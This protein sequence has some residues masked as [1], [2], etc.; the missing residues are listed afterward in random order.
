MKA[1]RKRISLEQVL[2]FFEQH[3]KRN[4]IL[5]VNKE[6]LWRDL[7]GNFTRCM[8]FLNQADPFLTLLH[9]TLTLASPGCR[10]L[11][12]EN[13][14]DDHLSCL[15]ACKEWRAWEG[16]KNGIL[17]LCTYKLFFNL[18]HIFWCIFNIFSENKRE[19]C[20]QTRLE[21]RRGKT[22]FIFLILA[23]ILARFDMRNTA[24]FTDKVQDWWGARTETTQSRNH[25]T[26]P[27]RMGPPDSLTNVLRQPI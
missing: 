2:T 25:K 3:G 24:T 1:R 6:N 11:I 19:Y 22:K 16:V 13:A 23:E 8:L 18:M 15:R 12:K 26:N 21:S 5:K 20:G 7:P 17:H 4:A 9:P 10:Y 27:V 14:I